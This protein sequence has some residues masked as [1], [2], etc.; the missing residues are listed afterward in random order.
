M[1]IKSRAANDKKDKG[2]KTRCSL[3]GKEGGRGDESKMTDGAPLQKCKII[4]KTST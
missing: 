4:L 3:T 2:K 1:D